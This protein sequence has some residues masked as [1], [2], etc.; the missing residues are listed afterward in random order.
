MKAGQGT[1]AGS[2]LLF[3]AIIVAVVAMM[4]IVSIT[5][6]PGLQTPADLSKT[7]SSPVSSAGLQLR[8][9]LNSTTIPQGGVVTAQVDLVNTLPTDVSLDASFSSNPNLVA[10]N[11]YNSGCGFSSVDHIFEYA[12]YSGHFTAANVSKA[13]PPLQLRPARLL[14]CLAYLHPEDYVKQVEF[15][16]NSDV[17]TLSANASEKGIFPSKQIKMLT[18]AST[19]A[20]SPAPDYASG[21]TTEA[22]G[23]ILSYSGKSFG[24]ACHPGSVLYGYWPVRTLQVCSADSQEAFDICSEGLNY[25]F[26]PF[27]D[28]SYTIVAEDMWNEVTFAYFRA[29]P[30]SSPVDVLSA[31]CP[32]PPYPCAHAASLAL[33]NVGNRTIVSLSVTLPKGAS[34]SQTPSLFSFNVNTSSPIFPFQTFRSTVTLPE[35]DFVDG[36]TYPMIFNGTLV[37]GAKFSHFSSTVQ[38]QFGA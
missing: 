19:E 8:I 2:S 28:G 16:A 36:V 1:G 37:D 7:F 21:S 13:G 31:T 3:A 4:G 5:T 18:N 35:T 15:P 26:Q 27:P 14:S 23:K 33:K 10:W 29:T 30:T 24:L 38:V 12:L 25:P 22:N 11:G 9:R 17:A 32:T 6:E 34:G 20:C